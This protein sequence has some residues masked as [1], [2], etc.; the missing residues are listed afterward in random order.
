VGVD[1]AEDVDP[2]ES[3]DAHQH[4]HHPAGNGP[5]KGITGYLVG[6]SFLFGRTKDA[7]LACDLTEVGAGDDVVDIGCGPGVALREARRR[8]AACTGVDPAPAMLRLGRTVSSRDITYV[9]G[10]AEALPLP[11][12]SA[13]VAWSLATAHH[14]ADVDQGLAE[15][16][17]VLRPDGRL[18]ILEHHS[19]PGAKGHAR[20][21]LTDQ[22]AAAFAAAC[23]AAG[24]ADVRVEE[25]EGRRG[26]ALAVLAVRPD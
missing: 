25:H 12:G 17:R 9:D 24:F 6:L 11:D 5:F 10:T 20:H 22:Q 19:T 4:H 18:L 1:P 8:G 21:G 3:T 23:T 16:R 2:A 26:P 13:S 15:A 14:W 7:R